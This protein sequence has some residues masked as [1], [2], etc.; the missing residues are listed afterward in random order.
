LKNWDAKLKG[1][2]SDGRQP[3]TERGCSSVKRI[4]AIAIVSV[5]LSGLFIETAYAKTYVKMKYSSS[6]NYNVTLQSLAVEG[7]KEIVKLKPAVTGLESGFDVTQ[8]GAKGNDTEDDT[9]AIQ[10]ALNKYDS[11]YI[12]DGIYMIDVEKSLK[13]KSNQILTMSKG[14]ILKAIPTKSSNYAILLISNANNVKVSGGQI[15]GDRFSHLGTKGEWGMGI[16][17]SDGSDS[18]E[19]T[20]VEISNCWGDGVYLGGSSPV[21]NITIKNIIS[22][23]NRRQGLSITN[24][25]AVTISNSVFKNTNGTAPEAG[26]DIEPNSNQKTEDITILNTQCY[27]NAGSGIDLVG[28]SEKVER[29]QVIGCTVKDN[30]LSGIRISNAN[31]LIFSNTSLINNNCGLEIPRDAHNIKFSEMTI[32][33]NKDRGV[34][35]IGTRQATGITNIVFEDS[36]I[37]NNSQLVR[38]S[39]D[40]VRIDNYDQ[41]GNIKDIAIKN[42][43]IGDDQTV[44]TQRYGIT[45]GFS[46]KIEGIV[47]KANIFSGNIKGSLLGSEAAVSFS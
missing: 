45:V 27:N 43:K 34:S 32:S 47:V 9:N 14:A 18:I 19:L 15:I 38:G 42:C 36:K 39:V 41:T 35:I 22:D 11:I 6:S 2:T 8:I 20:N 44:K 16:N 46:D 40:G 31:N 7:N 29:I 5:M 17:I 37:T 28:L 12:P 26:I 24:A 33:N 23:N 1:L 21:N 25:T 4:L 3:V 13:I 30:S 10:N